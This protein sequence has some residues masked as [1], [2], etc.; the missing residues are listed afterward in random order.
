MY[1]NSSHSNKYLYGKGELL[2]IHPILYSII[3]L[4]ER[5]GNLFQEVQFSTFDRL[6]YMKKYSFLKSHGYLTDI[7]GEKYEGVFVNESD[8]IDK[9]KNIKAISIEVTEMCNMKCEYCGYSD[10]Y[11]QYECVRTKN[12]IDDNIVYSL[13][14]EVSQYWDKKRNELDIIFY[15]GEPLLAFDQIKKIVDYLNIKF[16]EICFNYKIT[17]NG[18]LL[19]K[20]ISYLVEHN[21]LLS[22]SLDGNAY[23]N[24]FRRL[25]NGDNS[26]DLVAASIDAIKKMYPKYYSNNIHISSVL[27]SLN[28]INGIN[29]FI[30]ERFGLFSYIGELNTNNVKNV[31]KFNQIFKSKDGVFCVTT[32]SGDV[33]EQHR[34][35]EK[36]IDFFLDTVLN[37]KIM[38]I[39][40]L[41]RGCRSLIPTQKTCIPFTKELFLT[42][43]GEIYPCETIARIYPLGKISNNGNVD[44]SPARIAKLYN[45]KLNQQKQYCRSCFVAPFCFFCLFNV[46]AFSEKNKRCPEY[47][48]KDR[49]MAYITNYIDYFEEY[50]DEYVDFTLKITSK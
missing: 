9:L 28:S 22:I 21:F 12:I 4:V 1:T 35:N 31:S 18:L 42:V 44:L 25:K 19:N 30:K 13:L 41:R 43:K 36:S 49:F 15:G 45:D 6:Y 16:P 32:L 29:S 50:R 24:V 37:R 11:E 26:F 48:N 8:I 7:Y 46:L 3:E 23:S 5:K 17:T 27:H 40:D 10:M 14:N 2:L 34:P 38:K 20:Y 33:V 47:F 39:S